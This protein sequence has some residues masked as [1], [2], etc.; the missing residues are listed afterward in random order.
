M[1]CRSL[2]RQRIALFSNPYFCSIPPAAYFRPDHGSSW[3]SRADAVK[4][5]RRS[6]PSTS[7]AVSRPHL[8]GGEHGGRLDR[9][10]DGK[11]C[12]PAVGWHGVTSKLRPFARTAQAIL[13]SLLASAIASTL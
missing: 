13:A 12:Y 1:V 9:S 10:G 4:I 7:A 11:V 5:G 6:D 8:D 2:H 3:P